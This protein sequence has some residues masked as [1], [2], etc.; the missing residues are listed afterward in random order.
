MLFSPS[1]VLVFMTLITNGMAAPG[2]AKPP[3]TSITTKPKTSTSS[4]KPS[5]PKTTTT[6]ASPPPS[7]GGSFTG[8][9]T[10]YYTGGGTGACGF[11]LPDTAH[12]VAISDALY[13]TKVVNGNPNNNAYC[14]QCV[15]IFGSAGSVYAKVMD[16]CGSCA[17]YDL[18][19]AATIFP[20]VGD[21]AKAHKSTT[22]PAKSSS[23]SRS[24]AKAG[25]GTKGQKVLKHTTGIGKTGGK[26]TFLET[27]AFNHGEGT[28]YNTFGGYGACGQILSDSMA[29]AA[30]G[31]GL[32]DTKTING[33]PNNNAFCG[34]CIEVYG[35]FG[36]VTV[37]IMDRCEACKP[38][39]VD[40]TP[41]FFNKI[42]DPSKGRVPISWRFCD[43]SLDGSGSVGG[44]VGGTGGG[45]TGGQTGGDSGGDGGSSGQEGGDG[46]SGDERGSDE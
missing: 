42:D 43:G 32:F 8:Q 14:G 9:A 29:I 13:Q 10:Y 17:Y 6:S 12:I 11:P 23:P 45:D 25:A 31:H 46:N 18:D 41:T 4:S 16:R 26:K 38:N 39:D 36:S 19:I 27:T 5:A 24:K 40:L 44:T 3:S 1:K 35:A 21:M 15:Q 34:K 2:P 30:I 7:T 20:K 37:T 28:F 33:N 22:L